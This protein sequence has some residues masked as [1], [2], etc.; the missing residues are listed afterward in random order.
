M[1]TIS[2]YIFIV[3]ASSLVSGCF[4][5]DTNIKTYV[6][7]VKKTAPGKIDPLP[8][9]KVYHGVDFSAQ[10]YLSPFE[11]GVRT[12]EFGDD[13]DGDS[14]IKAHV[15]RPDAARKKE[16]LEQDPL[17][18]YVMV[19]TMSKGQKIWGLVKD[20]RGMVHVVKVG[21]YIGQNSGRIISISENEIKLMETKLGAAG[22]WVETN[23]TMEI[24]TN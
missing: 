6:E 1:M 18:S 21:D 22:D 13:E 23:N 20:R 17:N 7:T 3:F 14:K 8:P 12:G 2:K 15:P 9:V 5:R 4:D 10:N 19:G 16:F 11:K 24:K